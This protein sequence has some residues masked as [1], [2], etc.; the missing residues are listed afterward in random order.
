MR[1]AVRAVCA[2]PAVH[3]VAI[4]DAQRSLEAMPRL[5]T[6]RHGIRLED[7]R[8]SNENSRTWRSSAGWP[9]SGA[10]PGDRGSPA[11]R[12]A[13]QARRRDSAGVPDY[14]DRWWRRTSTA[15]R[16]I[17]R[18]GVPRGQERAAVNAS[19]LLFPI[20]W[21]EPFGLVMIEAMACGTPVSRSPGA[22]WRSGRRRRQRMCRRR[23]RRWRS[24]ARATSDSRP[25]RAGL[26]S[27]ATSASTA[28]RP[29]IES[30]YQ[31]CAG[32]TPQSSAAE[33]WS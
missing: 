10:A 26:T 4:S 7:Y 19:A 27:S 15:E 33:L 22:P 6:I 28:W 13:A 3:Y 30:L 24:A 23:C 1:R 2:L 32:S 8:T 21:H 17:R 31:A 5:T 29:I 16:R 14:W 9:R 20:Q 12:H 18:R 25:R 11:R